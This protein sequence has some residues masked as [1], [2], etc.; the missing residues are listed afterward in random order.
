VPEGHACTHDPPDQEGSGTSGAA[1]T[2]TR[3]PRPTAK[4][5]EAQVPDPPPQKEC[6]GETEEGQATEA[7]PTKIEQADTID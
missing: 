1:K 5:I 2:N 3:K 4:A 6:A 7:K